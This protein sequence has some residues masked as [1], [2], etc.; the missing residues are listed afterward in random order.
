LRRIP[1]ACVCQAGRR[2][3]RAVDLVWRIRE[4]DC[5]GD[6]QSGHIARKIVATLCSTGPRRCSCIRP[7]PCTAT[8]DLHAGRPHGTDFNR[9]TSAE[10]Q[11]LV[12]LLRQLPP[13]I[14][15]LGNLASPLASRWTFCWMRP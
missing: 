11:A 7:K 2:A 9:G 12:P 8:G 3:I 4:G 13:L 1:S 14:G 6:R 10:L 5:H 15:I